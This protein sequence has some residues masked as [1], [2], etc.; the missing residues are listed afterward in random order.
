[1]VRIDQFLKEMKR[2][3]ESL[4]Q[5]PFKIQGDTILAQ[6]FVDGRHREHTDRGR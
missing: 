5:K 3:L 1:M 6:D 4:K 2:V